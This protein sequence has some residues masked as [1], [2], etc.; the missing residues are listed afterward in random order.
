MT[1][2]IQNTGNSARNNNNSIYSNAGSNLSGV[3]YDFV[4]PLG[5]R[6]LIM[7]LISNN[8]GQLNTPQIQAP[9][10]ARMWFS[11]PRLSY[12]TTTEVLSV[13]FTVPVPISTITFD[14]LQVSC[15]VELWYVD[16]LNNTRPVLSTS[17]TP[18]TMNIIPSSSSNWYTIT[19]NFYPFTAKTLQFR[20]KRTPTNTMTKPYVVGIRNTYIRHNIYTRQ[21]AVGAIQPTQ[22]DM[23]NSITT[24]IR[25]YPASNAIDNKASTYWQSYPQPSANAVVCLYLDL[26]DENGNAQLID[27]VYLDPMYNGQNLNFYC[28]NDDT[29]GVLSL[30][31]VALIPINNINTD[32]ALGT[33]L[34]D[35][36]SITNQSALYQFPFQWGPLNKQSAWLGIEWTPD[37]SSVVTNT[38]QI[39][40]IQGNPTGGTWNLTTSPGTT[41][42][43]QIS[44]DLDYNASAAQVQ[45]ALNALYTGSAT[46]QAITVTGG[47]ANSEPFIVTFSGGTFTGTSVITMGSVN[48][49]TGGDYTP[50]IIPTTGDA[51]VATDPTDSSGIQI[52]IAT[53]VTGGLGEVD[54][55]TCYLFQ[56]Q[57][58]GIN[59]VDAVQTIS[60]EGVT[61]GGNASGGFILTFENASTEV[62][63][64][65]V[66]AAVMEAALQALP[67]INGNNVTVQQPISASGQWIITFNNGNQGGGILAAQPISNIVAQSYVTGGVSNASQILTIGGTPTGGSLQLTLP[68]GDVAIVPWPGA[69][70]ASASSMQSAIQ[71]VIPATTGPWWET[72]T[73]TTGVDQSPASV[74]VQGPITSG[75]NLI[76]AITF[77]GSEGNDVPLLQPVVTSLLGGNPTASIDYAAQVD[78]ATT[79][80][81]Q[82]PISANND[83]N[84][85]PTVSVTN[86]AVHLQFSNSTA[87]YVCPLSVP[88][89]A[90]VSMT[91]PLSA[92]NAANIVVAWDYEANE[93]FIQVV[94][95]GFV[96]GTYTNTNPNLPDVISLDGTISFRT[97]QGTFSA[98]VF[99]L[100]N[101]ANNY[102]AFQANPQVYVTP[103]VTSP[104]STNG[105]VATS[106]LDNAIYGACWTKQQFATGG[107]DP[108]K[109]EQKVWTPVY[110]TYT[111]AKGNC[112]FPQQYMTKYLCLEFY[113]LTPEPYVIYDTDIQ[114]TYQTFPY[115][116][117]QTSVQPLGLIGELAG[118]LTLG[119]DI[120]LSGIGSVNWLN[121]QTVNNAVNAVFGQTSAP[122]TVTS[123]QVLSSTYPALPNLSNGSTVV[124]STRTEV[125]SPWVYKRSPLNPSVLAGNV[126]KTTLQNS[127]QAVTT[128]QQGVQSALPPGMLNLGNGVTWTPDTNPGFSSSAVPAQGDDWW[129][130]PG[131]TLKMPAATM[132]GLTGSTEVETGPGLSTVTTYRFNGI[133]KHVYQTTTV[134]LDASIA[135]YAGVREV[136]PY[137]TTYV[138]SEDP[139][140]FRFTRYD[141]VQWSFYNINQLTGTD[142]THLGPITTAGSLYKIQNPN[143][144]PSQQQLVGSDGMI[145]DAGTTS[146]YNNVVSGWIQ[147][148]GRWTW[149]GTI[150]VVGTPTGGSYQLVISNTIDPAQTFVTDFI[151]YNADAGDI[152]RALYNLSVLTGA[153][154]IV[155][156]GTNPGTFVVQLSNIIDNEPF[157]VT[158]ATSWLAG[159]SIEV[160]NWSCEGIFTIPADDN[161]YVQLTLLNSNTSDVYATTPRIQTPVTV[162]KIM[163]ALA[164]VVP[165]ETQISVT[166]DGP[167]TISLSSVIGPSLGFGTPVSELSS[168][169]AATMTSTENS[170][171]YGGGWFWDGTMGHWDLGSATVTG[172]GEEQVL[173]SS[174]VDVTPGASVSLAGWTT[175]QNLVLHNSASPLLG[176]SPI[177]IQAWFYGPNEVATP[178][179]PVDINLGDTG[180][181]PVVYSIDPTQWPSVQETWPTDCPLIDGNYWQHITENTVGTPNT[182]FTVPSGAAQMR[183][184]LVVTDQVQSGQVWFDTIEVQGQS[185]VEGRCARMFNTTNTFTKLT[186][187][188]QDSGSVRSDSMW[189]TPDVADTNVPSTELAYYTSLFPDI[190]PSGMWADAFATWDSPE[191]VWGEPEAVVDVSVSQNMVYQNKRALLFKRKSGAGAAGIQVTQSTNF[192]PN[193]LA[194]LGC[195][196]Y[197]PPTGVGG[198]YTVPNVNPLPTIP[199]LAATLSTTVDALKRYNPILETDGVYAGL[200][201]TIPPLSAS[202]TVPDQIQLELVQ[203]STGATIYSEVFTPPEGFWY[204]HVTSFFEVPD[205]PDQTYN[206]TLTLNGNL[207]DSLYI[208]DLY[209]EIANVRYFVQLGGEQ[210]Y[211]HDVTPL[212]FNGG[213][214]VVSTTTPVNTFIVDTVVLSPD[215]Y[216]YGCSFQP[217]YVK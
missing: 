131:G 164:Q 30:S 56:A 166:D 57:P 165:E 90:P 25:D 129:V 138:D 3:Y 108:S 29:I 209:T 80:A 127:N 163:Q 87:T 159:G 216:A 49:L 153:D 203:V 98:H 47:P 68:N 139:I 208:N 105:V 181:T 24:S 176:N 85:Y 23:G 116:V 93:V 45:N 2:S 185:L 118:L 86:G 58:E 155:D 215:S 11:Q 107:D 193:A 151:P 96:V 212:A 61:P 100:E 72:T 180:I 77:G 126:I 69:T 142:G 210:S 158:G 170:L 157:A 89:N 83:T 38:V 95:Q 84:S 74:T 63:S 130:F 189:A 14:I 177:Q 60:L 198:V 17:K 149:S 67:T 206:L 27:T 34:W 184:A 7:Q 187:E 194:R 73:Q 217:G 46:E 182:Q 4:I 104:V 154:I 44:T 76:Y 78:V 213:N 125:S 136:Q 161:G 71:N 141:P 8:Q 37:F 205:S 99:K 150:T 18:V 169:T 143:F 97:F 195:I 43:N 91:S 20:I 200:V 190:V 173:L 55:E 175:W 144:D 211:M 112:Y 202:Q 59:G 70:G 204:E 132:K 31:S 51:N 120:V 196:F 26:R 65:D 147:A 62:L 39:I 32:W 53:T 207:P 102:Q 186:C 22:D 172:N 12:D 42:S 121:P 171:P 41:N 64:Y 28:S 135:Y 114:T 111:T 128:G 75:T 179:D 183:I 148:Q 9:S 103:P 21:D 106:T 140:N 92:G 10:S 191:I 1:S 5:L 178:D 6:N 168:G 119:A 81:G 117:T 35:T 188:F 152:Q 110:G 199:A 88:S 15:G 40:D 122:A 146:S 101:Y 174:A 134:T 109:Y 137:V 82:L 156:N 113:N 123:G 50:S 115:S 145:I 66:T 52:S 162:A 13:N 192:V 201:L 94:S 160:S 19:E 36:S 133:E 54:S 33:G 16:D 214:A 79:T 197:K 48:A 124:N 167:Y